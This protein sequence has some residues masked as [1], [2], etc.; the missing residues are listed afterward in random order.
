METRRASAAGQR[1]CLS[2]QSHNIVKC[3]ALG[4]SC[5]KGSVTARSRRPSILEEVLCPFVCRPALG[6]NTTAANRGIDRSGGRGTGLHP[7]FPLSLGAITAPPSVIANRPIWAEGLIA[8]LS[9]S[10]E[11]QDI[12]Q[13]TLQDF[14]IFF[15]NCARQVLRQVA[16]SRKGW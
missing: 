7:E 5:A 16:L 4:T 13:P 8:R 12:K 15:V 11:G 14:M 9:P 6:A 1:V 3:A 2:P 10:T